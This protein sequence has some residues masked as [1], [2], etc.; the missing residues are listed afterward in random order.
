[1]DGS[2]LRIE[3]RQHGDVSVVRNPSRLPRAAHTRTVDAPQEGFLVRLDAELVGRSSMLLGAGR[4]RV[5]AVID[6]A[7]G[8]VVDKKLGERV[9]KG[10]PIMTLHYNDPKRL[11]AAMQLA[12]SAIHVGDTQPPDVPLVRAWVHEQGETSYV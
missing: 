11:E 12:G 4:D 2:K 3:E 8:V 7:T 1:M 5:E 6:P 9:R 10:E